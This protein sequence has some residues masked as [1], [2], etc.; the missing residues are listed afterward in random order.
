MSGIL[1]VVGTPIGNLGDVSPRVREALEAADVIAAEDTRRIGNLLASLGIG[2]KRLLSYFKDNEKGRV[3]QLVREMAEGNLT[4]VLVS[5]S[6]MPA[7]ADPG[8][9]LVAAARAAGMRVEVIPGPSAVI[10]A[11]AGSGL[12][13]PFVFAGFLP[14]KGKERREALTRLGT[15]PESIV[16]YESPFRVAETAA[17][18]AAAWG[19]RP[20][21]LARELT[22]LHEEWIG[23]D[24]DS[25][26]TTLAAREVKGECVFIVQGA[27]PVAQQ[28]PAGR[29]QKYPQ[30]P[31]QPV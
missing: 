19:N 10:H 14:R 18:F 15:Y 25:I 13:G 26:K 8:A 22:K 4:T 5:D 12:P 30:P 6:G 27:V 9:L 2:K 11:V 7:V 23:P 3:P 29:K 20:A 31:R 24:L 16:V 17:D 1:K 28:K 21:W